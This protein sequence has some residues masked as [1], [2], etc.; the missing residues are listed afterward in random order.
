MPIG[1]PARHQQKTTRCV[2]RENPSPRTARRAMIGLAGVFALFATACG[3]DDGAGS[4][5]GSGG[6]DGAA[7]YAEKCAS[8]HGADLR[9]TSKGPS[10][11]SSVYKPD[12]HPDEAFRSAILNGAPQHHWPFGPMPPIPGMDDDEITAVIQYIRDQQV[13]QGFFG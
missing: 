10:H 4:G 7:I 8:C 12:H 9:G 11:L 13:E 5:A 1:A 2:P 6:P 3:N